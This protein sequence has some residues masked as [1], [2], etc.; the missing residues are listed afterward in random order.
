M[1]L[2]PIGL[3]SNHLL[4]PCRVVPF[5]IAH[6]SG[7]WELET[8]DM[9]MPFGGVKHSS[10][11]RELGQSALGYYSEQKSVFISDE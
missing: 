3:S 2:F 9:E 11:G 4:A 8:G 5:V 10:I 7:G 1:A 6:S